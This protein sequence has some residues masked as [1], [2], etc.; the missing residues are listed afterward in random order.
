MKMNRFNVLTKKAASLL[1]AGIIST[2]CAY[3]NINDIA[4]AQAA[5]HSDDIDGQIVDLEKNLEILNKKKMQQQAEF[6][7]EKISNLEK[8]IENINKSLAT[9]DKYDAKGAIESLEGQLN[10][11]KKQFAQQ[12][13]INNSILDTL[14]K[15]QEPSS[16][17]S[18]NR[19]PLKT[20]DSYTDT[21]SGSYRD[22]DDKY[23]YNEYS[24]N[25]RAA[26]VNTSSYLVNPAPAK[27]VNYTQDA[28]NSQGTS[29]MVFQYSPNQ[30]YKVYC[31][32]G[33]LTDIALK[34]GETI[35]FVGGGDTAAWMLDTATVG[36]TPHLYIKPIS[37]DVNTNIVVNTTEHTYQLILNSSDWYNPMIRWNYGIEN[38]LNAKKQKKKDEKIIIGETNAY[39]VDKLNFN[40]TVS[41]NQDWKP[42]MVFDDGQKTYIKFK[43]LKSTMPVLFIRE[44]NKKSV[45]MVNYKVKDDCYIVDKLFDEAQL[46]MNDKD[47]VTIAAD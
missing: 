15:L 14:K 4:V 46:R 13:E 40:Y 34:D 29:T 27:N 43:K 20:D 33:Y 30:L 2:V 23:I 19:N 12:Q 22:E 37:K 21:Y 31:R 9:Q 41:G 5:A 32:V 42:V 10:D 18:R 26:G 38:S 16:F 17:S 11:I 7:K 24:D 8:S 28:I 36:S 3:G 25:P 44:K 45:S 1:I 35:T 6:T 39:S 47:I